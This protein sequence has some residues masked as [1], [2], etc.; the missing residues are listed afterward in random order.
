[1]RPGLQEPCIL[2]DCTVGDAYPAGHEHWSLEVLLAVI[3]SAT[4]LEVKDA[5]ATVSFGD[6]C[7]YLKDGASSDDNPCYVWEALVDGDDCHAAIISRYRTPLLFGVQQGLHVPGD[8]GDLL[9]HAGEDGLLFGC[10]RW[11]LIGPPRSGSSL[12][13]DPLGTS[14]WNMLLLGSKLWCVF[15]PL[16]EAEA[17]MLV[18]CSA[19]AEAGDTDVE[20][21]DEL[22]AA[23][24]FSRVLPLLMV[25]ARAWKPALQP[26]CFIQ[27]EGETVYIPAGYHHAVI[28]LTD[29]VCVTQNWCEPSNYENVCREIYGESAIGEEDK[30]A[31]RVS[32]DATGTPALCVHCG[33][34]TE[35]NTFPL[36]DD[37]PLCLSC[38]RASRLY[39]L[40]TA[41]EAEAGGV[42]VWK[43]RGGD[44][45]PHIE[46]RGGDSSRLYSVEHIRTIRRERGLRGVWPAPKGNTP[47]VGPPPRGRGR[48]R[49]K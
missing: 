35:C 23:Q 2:V 29:T 48:G 40:C 41:A 10:H 8:A 49:R 13:V 20:G 27:N 32:C 42:C 4:R 45:P 28:N 30:D 34:D 36:F 17:T 7:K 6:Y 26:V 11:L 21:G 19:L 38:Q 37:R 14:A 15:P 16:G 5:A 44:V 31:W 25:A 33:K 39:D 47:T 1:M 18:A 46:G 3:G 22:C 9:S 24:W 43:L 12:H